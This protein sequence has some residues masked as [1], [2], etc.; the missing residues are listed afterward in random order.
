[1]EK[2]DAQRT[3]KSEQLQRAESGREKKWTEEQRVARCEFEVAV[4]FASQNW[5]TGIALENSP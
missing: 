4:R 3:A 1:M 5:R 2:E